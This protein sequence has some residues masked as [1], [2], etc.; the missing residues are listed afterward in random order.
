M[1]ADNQRGANKTQTW[2]TW[3]QPKSPSLQTSASV[4]I[5]L[6]GLR[7]RWTMRASCR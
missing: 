1:K 2:G 6:D 3:Q 7:S 4:T 5:T